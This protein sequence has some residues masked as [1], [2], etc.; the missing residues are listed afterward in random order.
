MLICARLVRDKPR[1]VRTR[2]RTRIRG[3]PAMSG[4]TCNLAKARGL[5][6]RGLLFQVVSLMGTTKI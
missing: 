4:E 3:P 2:H 5:A 6:A 1:R